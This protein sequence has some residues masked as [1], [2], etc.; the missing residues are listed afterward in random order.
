MQIAALTEYPD[1]LDHPASSQIFPKDAIKRARSIIEDVGSVGAYS[2][3]MGVPAI[4]KRIARFIES[5]LSSPP[6]LSHLGFCH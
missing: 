2:H 4:R 3:S 6:S 1:L 5:A